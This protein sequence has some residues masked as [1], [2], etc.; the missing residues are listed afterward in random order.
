M[1][2]ELMLP[3]F[4]PAHIKVTFPIPSKSYQLPYSLKSVLLG[5]YKVMTLNPE[6]K[7]IY[8]LLAQYYTNPA[9]SHFTSN[10]IVWISVYNFLKNLGK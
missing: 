3:D 9:I 4:S 8:L 2:R 6:R 5:G 7:E 10:C 1:Q